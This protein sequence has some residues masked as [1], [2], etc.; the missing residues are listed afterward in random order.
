MIWN[1]RNQN[2]FS[3]E[4]FFPSA[5]LWRPEALELQSSKALKL[6]SRNILKLWSCLAVEVEF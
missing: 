3:S 4:A 6:W 1:Y 5:V 2:F